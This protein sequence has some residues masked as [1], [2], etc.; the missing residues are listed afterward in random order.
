[1]THTP[2]PIPAPKST[3][4]ED[5]RKK[6]RDA[7]FA[8]IG[9]LRRRSLAGAWALSLFLL[10]AIA[11]WWHFPLLPSPE[12]LSSLL[13]SPPSPAVISIAF[14]VY[15]F[16]AIILSL[17]RMMTG[18]EQYNIVGHIGYLAGFF[19]F[20]HAAG[21]L[22]ENFW[23]VFAGGVTILV[24]D[25]YRIRQF[26]HERIERLHDRLEHLEKSGHLPIDD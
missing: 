9:G 12:T 16:F 19:F 25:G 10:L 22:G 11:A 8:E 23:A 26:C 14:I 7:I 2:Q 5:T 24:V 13:G 6:T 3:L 4:A 18:A 20:Y 1:M 15:I 21:A 17:A